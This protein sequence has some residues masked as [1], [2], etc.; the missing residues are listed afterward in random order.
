MPWYRVSNFDSAGTSGDLPKQAVPASVFT[1][2]QNVT[3]RDGAVEKVMGYAAQFGSALNTPE[4]LV[5]GQ[6]NSGNVRLFSAG[7]TSIAEYTGTWADVTRA[8]GAYTGG[9][10][11][12]WNG[13]V[14][15]GITVLNNGIDAP[16]YFDTA[17]GKFADLTNWPSGYCCKSLRAFK[18]YLVA[19]NVTTASADYPHNI[20]WS[21]PADPGTLPVSWDVADTTKDA[22]EVP[23]SETTGYLVDGL[24]L[25]NSFVLYKEDS[26]YLMQES[27]TQYIFSV[28]IA[29]RESGVLGKNCIVEANRM[30][31]VLTQDDVIVFNG[32]QA[33]SIINKQWRRDLFSRLAYESAHQ[34]FVF[35]RP[36]DYEI[37]ICISTQSGFAADLAYVYNWK[38]GKWAKRELPFATSLAY[39][40]PPELPATWSGTS[41][42]WT[43]GTSAWRQRRFKQA[44]MS[45][46]TPANVY[47]LDV[48]E[49]A[50]GASFSASVTHESFDFAGTDQRIADSADR[51]KFIKRL[52]I[53][54]TGS[55]GATLS[56]ELGTQMN[57]ADAIDWGT[58]MSFALD[59]GEDLFCSRN[60]RYISWRVSSSCDCSWRLESIDAEVEIGGRF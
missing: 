25:G 10:A 37:W 57:L 13:T 17:T 22:G 48:T 35:H 12:I 44:L 46:N 8:S 42:A 58:A 54:A 33:E 15:H 36:D 11:D 41:G 21:H 38:S 16:Q 14:L 34:C 26:T 53:R 43:A 56:V 40:I 47:T 39:A 3:F 20:L 49:Q 9:A 19:L 24:A 52:R 32:T 31:Y 5:T 18:N 29:L 2:A 45:S 4:W 1:D 50:A 23:L 55:A 51:I 28:A 59:T 6:D 30:H 27:G 60:G 7:L